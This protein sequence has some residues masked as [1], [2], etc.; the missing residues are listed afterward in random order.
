M[1]SFLTLIEQIE[2]EL[3]SS[4]RKVADYILQNPSAPLFMTMTEL[5][6]AAGSS[7]AIVVRLCKRL[8][9]DGYSDF[10]IRLSR[11]VFA[12][13]TKDE[14][15]EQVMENFYDSGLSTSELI[16]QYIKFTSKNLANIESVLDPK[17]V[18]EA[19]E[20]IY[21][22]KTI[23]L[24]GQGSAEVVLSD[25][26]YKLAR[27]GKNVIY[28]KDV[29]LQIAQSYS[30]TT[31]MV[32]FGISYFGE[33]QLVN[34]AAKSIK[35]ANGKLITLTKIG[36]NHLSRLA[37]I[38]LQIPA[39]GYEF[40]TGSTLTRILQIFVTDVLYSA[41]L[42]KMSEDEKASVLR[43]WNFSVNHS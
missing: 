3:P 11:E 12:N 29:N 13:E 31:D 15:S 2:K 36:H 24:I 7:P 5:S 27:L 8:N 20:M 37:D 19:A 28:S 42:G 34:Q 25:L 18:D 38:K 14:E 9:V 33:D 41:C 1:Q 32:A 22:A 6:A 26:Q 21:Q 35:E 4:E 16:A 10:K 23:L 39:S 40:R 30:M 17:T 43:R